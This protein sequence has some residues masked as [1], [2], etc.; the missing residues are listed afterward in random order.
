MRLHVMPRRAGGTVTPL[1]VLVA[2]H[3][4]LLLLLVPHA[5]HERLDV[6]VGR[7]LAVGP[8]RERGG[9]GRG[10]PPERGGSRGSPLRGVGPPSHHVLE[11]TLE[12]C[13]RHGGGGQLLRRGR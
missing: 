12:L 9:P 10:L 13:L 6:R 4:L 8:L 3:L 5:V 11:R 2:C 7:R 1:G